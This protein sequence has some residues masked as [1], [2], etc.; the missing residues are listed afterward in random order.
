MTHAR[1]SLLG[2]P[3]EHHQSNH[4]TSLPLLSPYSH[5]RQ[6]Q[7]SP[8]AAVGYLAMYLSEQAKKEHIKHALPLNS[9]RKGAKLQ[10]LDASPPKPLPRTHKQRERHSYDLADVKLLAGSLNVKDE[11]RVKNDPSVTG[12]SVPSLKIE[13]QDVKHQL[14]QAATQLIAAK[15]R[16]QQSQLQNDTAL[17]E[18]AQQ[19]ADE[20]TV[21]GLL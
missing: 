2:G 3:A 8:V 17:V 12:S 1:R 15:Q 6:E 14:D 10:K 4:S 19:T 11:K 13:L 9:P 5:P 7:S 21:R 20:S 18:L 16:L